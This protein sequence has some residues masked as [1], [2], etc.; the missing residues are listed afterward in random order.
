MD[1][2]GGRELRE[3][4]PRGQVEEI[5]PSYDDSYHYKPISAPVLV[6]RWVV[7]PRMKRVA[8]DNTQEAA[9]GAYDRTMLVYGLNKITTATR[10]ESAM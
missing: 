4:V 3:L 8:S 6:L 5:L 10:L 1:R 7:S 9:Q 2:W